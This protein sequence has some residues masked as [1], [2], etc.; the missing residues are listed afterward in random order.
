VNGD[1]LGGRVAIDV[2]ARRAWPWLPVLG[3]TGRIYV[4]PTGQTLRLRPDGGCDDLLAV[5]RRWSLSAD[6]TATRRP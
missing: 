5:P 2:R 1:A 3:R 4:G 6:P